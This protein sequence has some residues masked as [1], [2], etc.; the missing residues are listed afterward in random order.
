MESIF[1]TYIDSPQPDP[2][3]IP[4][5]DGFDVDPADIVACKDMGF[6]YRVTLTN[7]TRRYV[8]Y[9]DL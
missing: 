6:G 3:L 1:A 4:T 8:D 9:G 2:S 5:T 7:G